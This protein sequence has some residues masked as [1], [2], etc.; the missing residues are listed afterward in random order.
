[1]ESAYTVTHTGE[2]IRDKNENRLQGVYPL[3]FLE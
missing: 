2:S 1:M 3:Q